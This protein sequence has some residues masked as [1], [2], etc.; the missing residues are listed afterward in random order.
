MD[1]AASVM[2]TAFG[3]CGSGEG[4][5]IARPGPDLALIAIARLL[6]GAGLSG[7]RLATAPAR[8]QGTR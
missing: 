5:G 7:V 1:I 4:M 2:I 8:T 6:F 3:I